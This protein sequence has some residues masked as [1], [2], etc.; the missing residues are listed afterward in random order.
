[1]VAGKLYLL[2][3]LIFLYHYGYIPDVLDHKDRDRSNNKIEN[4]RAATNSINA[5]NTKVYKSSTTGVKGVTFCQTHKRFVAS[6]QRNKKK[7]KK[8]FGDLDAA[9]NWRDQVEAELDGSL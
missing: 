3:R 8:Y 4:L 5:S 9:K 6:I 2:H 1:M 7:Y